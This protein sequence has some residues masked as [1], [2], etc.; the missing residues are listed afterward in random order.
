MKKKSNKR[1]PVAFDLL[2]N[3]L[4]RPKRE[5]DK[6]KESKRKPEWDDGS[7]H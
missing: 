7:E 4:Y 1:D 5:T 6:K 2:T 3:G